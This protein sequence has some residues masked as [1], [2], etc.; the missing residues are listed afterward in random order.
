MQSAFVTH[1]ITALE[2]EWGVFAVDLFILSCP[3]LEVLQEIL[4]GSILHF[5]TVLYIIEI[6]FSS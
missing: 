2:G 1:L 4:E 3:D 6:L 5:G